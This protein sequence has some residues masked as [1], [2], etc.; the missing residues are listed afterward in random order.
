MRGG[1]PILGTA[2]DLNLARGDSLSVAATFS[3]SEY[4]H[5]IFLPVVKRN[6]STEIRIIWH[7]ILNNEE[8]VVR[9][10]LEREGYKGACKS[11]EHYLKDKARYVPPPEG[12]PI[13]VVDSSQPLETYIRDILEFIK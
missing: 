9:Q 7:K 3:R 11:L 4:W 2:A 1:Y 8:A 6:P 13:M 12:L 10:R 5:D